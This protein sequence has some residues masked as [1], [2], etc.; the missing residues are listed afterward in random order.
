MAAP[1]NILDVT[2]RAT[3]FL[4][5]GCQRSGTTLMKLMLECHTDI[6]CYDER[7]GYRILS[8]V[9]H[10]VLTGLLT[11][12]KAPRITEQLQKR[13]LRDDVL[14]P[15]RNFYRG[16]KIVFMV[17][18]ARDTVVSMTRLK[19]GRIDWLDKWGIP[20]IQAKLRSDRMFKRRY[21]SVVKM[22]QRDKYD[23]L[24]FGA[25]CWKYKTEAVFEYLARGYPV[26]VVK[27]EQLISRSGREMK[28]V[29]SFLG[30]PWQDSVLRHNEVKHNETRCG[31]TIGGTDSSRAVD[32]TSIGQWRDALSDEQAASIMRIV[33]PTYVAVEKLVS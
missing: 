28:S 8:G 19:C 23:K 15:F 3:V 31:V 14:P 10:A 6:Q 13:T 21:E 32:S 24:C 29:C 20:A 18:D 12:F 1:D 2:D 17:R 4:I 22:C 5:L 16:Q 33:G 30:V 26:H 7:C 11:G 25:L 27:Y 9:R